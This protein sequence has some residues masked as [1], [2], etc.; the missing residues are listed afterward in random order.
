M[1]AFF[2]TR[3][4][5]PQLMHRAEAVFR[6]RGFTGGLKYTLS[7]GELLL[8][9]KQMV[10]VVNHCESGAWAVYA[11][12][13]PVYR[14]L[15]YADTLAALVDDMS[16]GCL[17][18]S[19]LRGSFV[20][21]FDNRT[22][23]ETVVLTDE[24]GMYKLF[25]DDDRRFLSSSFLAAAA[26]TPC[27][28]NET[29]LAEQVLCGFVSAPDTL[30]KEV[31]D[32]RSAE[33]RATLSFVKWAEY[34]TPAKIKRS[35]NLEASV[36][37]QTE[38]IRGYMNDVRALVEEYGGECGLSGGCDSRLIYASTAEACH[39]LR[40]VHTHQTGNIH[41]KEIQTVEKLV[42][43]YQ[44]PLRILPTDYILDCPG[45]EIDATL[46]ENVLYFDGRNATTIGSFSKTHTRAYRRA[47]ADSSGVTFSGIAGE[48]Y[49]NFYYTN[50]PVFS[51]RRWLESRIFISYGDCII[52]RS[53]YRET[54]NRILDKIHG[55]TG[56]RVRP[57]AGKALAKRFF[58][59][60]RIPCAL[61]NAVHA[62]NQMSFYLTPFTE[63]TLIRAAAPDARYQDQCGYMEGKIIAR[64]SPRAA[65]LMSA[66]GYAFSHIPRK[67]RMMWRIKGYLPSGMWKKR[68]LTE[69]KHP[70]FA[71][72]LARALDET[73]YFSAALNRFRADYPDWNIEHMLNGDVF[74]NSFMFTVCTL[75]ELSRMRE[76]G[77]PT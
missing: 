30:V 68:K 75:Y 73:T 51:A 20:L 43:L 76:E 10:E 64:F 5:N 62:N 23:G 11:V 1:A 65:D 35:R 44:T 47:T 58:D 17:D 13:A 34:P 18:Q 57:F 74:A 38:L 21:L 14:G 27:T 2:L 63:A 29:A 22:G 31:T 7:A 32:L 36:D 39:P 59:G 71:A 3:G 67:T 15:S 16:R 53:L 8:F 12:G 52:P 9:P 19:A 61:S 37:R 55:A 69:N 25:S 50:L 33:A 54:V 40:S 70:A 56:V 28:I 48:I 42:S 41:K 72:S 60:H 6:E 77:A 46:R 24:T 4:Q 66:K 49:R 26:C 45:A